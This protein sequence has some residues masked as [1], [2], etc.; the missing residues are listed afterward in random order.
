MAKITM[1]LLALALAGVGIGADRTDDATLLDQATAPPPRAAAQELGRRMNAPALARFLESS[2]QALVEAWIAGANETGGPLSP[3]IEALA[4]RYL[5]HPKLGWRVQ[6]VFD[7]TRYTQTATFDALARRLCEQ[8]PSA[9]STASHLVHTDLPIADGVVALLPQAKSGRCPLARWLGTQRYAPAV[10]A[11]RGSLADAGPDDV[12]CLCGALVAIGTPEAGTALGDFAVA[13]LD[14]GDRER[15]KRCLQGAIYNVAWNVELPPM[16]LGMLGGVVRRVDDDGASKGYL[17]LV[18]RTHAGMALEHVLAYLDRDPGATDGLHATAFGLITELDDPTAWQHARE[19]LDRLRVEEH[20]DEGYYRNEIG[21]LDTMLHD[22]DAELARRAAHRR[23]YQDASALTN[24]L[25]LP[26]E[27]REVAGRL[28]LQAPLES[29]TR[30]QERY[31]R[32]LDRVLHRDWESASLVDQRRMAANECFDLATIVRVRLGDPGRSLSLAKRAARLSPT[33][34]TGALARM[35]IAEINRYERADKARARRFYVRLRRMLPDSRLLAVD[36]Q[37]DRRGMGR[38]WERWIDVETRYL[39]TGT[40]FSGTVDRRTV[41]EFL[42]WAPLFLVPATLTA[43]PDR[44]TVASGGAKIDEFTLAAAFPTSVSSHI[45][46]L[47]TSPGLSVLSPEH[48]LAYLEHHDPARFWS[49]TLLALGIADDPRRTGG[50]RPASRTFFFVHPP[51]SPGTAEPWPI[52]MAAETF[53]SKT[54]IT[55]AMEPFPRPETAW[56]AFLAGLRSGDPERALGACTSIFARELLPR[57]ESMTARDAAGLAAISGP[58]S[59]VSATTE[60][61]TYLVS[62]LGSGPTHQ[63]L[64]ARDGLDWLVAGLSW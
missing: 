35:E 13:R 51:T 22:P 39:D 46:L 40:P 55:I 61:A 2:D 47:R 34:A 23:A 48:L 62:P 25:A 14:R 53:A 52:A 54:G 57:L 18:R 17:D 59:R 32:A 7:H 50:E 28:R 4:I 12:A 42:A 45:V 33:D 11:I 26:R 9:E 41:Q 56:Q 38:W 3:A 1:V 16:D 21:R 64:F 60:T 24:A 10:P 43:E 63:V 37:V 30:A 49:A 29:W 31:L 36:P 58:L 5:D 8:S 19:R 44:V 20:A 6:A 15:A 27:R